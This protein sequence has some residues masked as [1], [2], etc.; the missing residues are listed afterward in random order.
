MM[1]TD[2]LTN[3]SLVSACSRHVLLQPNSGSRGEKALLLP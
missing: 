1:C 2:A 3:R